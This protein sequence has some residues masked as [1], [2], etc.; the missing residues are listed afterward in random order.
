MGIGDYNR[1]LNKMDDDSEIEAHEIFKQ[2][3]D[4]LTT[5]ENFGDGLNRF[6][7]SIDDR[8]PRRDLVLIF[9]KIRNEMEAEIFRLA[10]SSCYAEAKEMKGRLTLIR[11]E[12]DNLQLNGAANVR[13]DQKTYFEK[14]T[15]FI[16]QDLNKKHVED[17][18]ELTNQFE[19]LR[20][21][22]DFYH[23]IQTDNLTQ[24]ISKIH[25]PKM[26]FKKGKRSNG[27][28]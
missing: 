10:N 28:Y 21:D 19:R 2:E 22:E 12:F 15:H 13:N 20:S 11:E 7:Y 16:N 4:Q 23:T 9:T 26:R 25:K 5:V 18:K 24:T 3:A 6:G 14:A 17:I 27:D 8:I 1:E